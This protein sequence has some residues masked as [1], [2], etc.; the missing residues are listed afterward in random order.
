MISFRLKS[1][2]NQLFTDQ[3]PWTTSSCIVSTYL[4]N[5]VGGTKGWRNQFKWKE[6]S[7]LQLSL[8]I[9][10]SLIKFK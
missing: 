3:S 10:Q 2:N 1:N 6:Y 5:N 9:S 4:L 8:Q 7:D